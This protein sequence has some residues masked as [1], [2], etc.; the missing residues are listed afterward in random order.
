MGNNMD[1]FIYFARGSFV[2]VS[3]PLLNHNNL[4]KQFI[5]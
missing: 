1:K 4:I 2:L 5:R 3:C